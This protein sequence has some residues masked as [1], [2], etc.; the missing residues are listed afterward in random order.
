MTQNYGLLLAGHA[1]TAP[2]RIPGTTYGRAMAA[3][4]RFLAR[5]RTMVE[6]GC[7]STS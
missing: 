7:A 6:E 4:D 5:I 2:V 3:R 1:A